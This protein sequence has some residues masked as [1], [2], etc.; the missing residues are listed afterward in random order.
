MEDIMNYMKLAEELLN[1]PFV[2]GKSTT[3]EEN[4]HAALVVEDFVAEKWF[5]ALVEKAKA[6]GR[7]DIAKMFEQIGKGEETHAEALRKAKTILGLN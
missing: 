7:E 1:L 6:D 4:V 5:P 2:Q 3:T